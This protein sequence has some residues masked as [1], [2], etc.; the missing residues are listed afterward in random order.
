MNIVDDG[1]FHYDMKYP[2]LFIRPPFHQQDQYKASMEG[3]IVS[4]LQESYRNGIKDPNNILPSGLSAGEAAVHFV[5]D[6]N[7]K[8]KKTSETFVEINTIIEETLQ[9]VQINMDINIAGKTKILF[10]RYINPDLFKSKQYKRKFLPALKSFLEE[11]NLK[12]KG[13]THKLRQVMIDVNE[14]MERE[15]KEE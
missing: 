4:F 13:Y 12:F 5:R 11:M 10:Y 1:F 15:Y 9:S 14:I 7:D 8:R 6:L 2:P 3:A